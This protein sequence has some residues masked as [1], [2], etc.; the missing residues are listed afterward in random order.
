M[1][2]SEINVTWGPAK[3]LDSMVYSNNIPDHVDIFTLT[4]LRFPIHDILFPIHIFIP[5]VVVI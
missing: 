4:R 5:P 1:Q 2:E 3:H